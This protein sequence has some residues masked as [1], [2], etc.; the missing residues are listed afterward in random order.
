MK[1]ILTGV[2]SELLLCQPDD[3]GTHAVQEVLQKVTIYITR[4]P[5]AQMQSIRDKY[6][7]MLRRCHRVSPNCHPPANG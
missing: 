1:R 5:Q 3:V 6:N 2:V 4:D 7:I